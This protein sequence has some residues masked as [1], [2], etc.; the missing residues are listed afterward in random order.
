MNRL[1]DGWIN[2]LIDLYGRLSVELNMHGLC[3]AGPSNQSINRSID[4]SIIQS[5]NPQHTQ[6]TISTAV[7][8]FHR[9]FAARSLVEYEAGGRL[10]ILLTTCLFLAAKVGF[11]STTD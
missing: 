10:A 5:S 8:V 2:Q 6:E 7:L 11:N 1:I 3:C 9:F 4:R